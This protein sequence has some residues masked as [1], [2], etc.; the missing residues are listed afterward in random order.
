MWGTCLVGGVT[1]MSP[2]MNDMSPS[3]ACCELFNC[4]CY[5]LSLPNQEEEEEEEEEEEKELSGMEPCNIFFGIIII[6]F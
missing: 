1:N 4:F 3:V 5:P 6:L 2:I